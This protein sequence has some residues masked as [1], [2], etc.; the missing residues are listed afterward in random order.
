[1]CESV[2]LSV[3]YFIQVPILPGI[4]RRRFAG[5]ERGPRLSQAVLNPHCGRVR[6]TKHAPRNPCCLLERRH[7][8]AE[9]VECGAG[10]P[11]GTRPTGPPRGARVSG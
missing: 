5:A 4:R 9:I 2:F 1:M 11:R 7:C 6:A 3:L 10:V 8:L